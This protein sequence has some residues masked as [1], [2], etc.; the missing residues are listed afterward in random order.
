MFACMTTVLPD[1]MKMDQTFETV[2][3]PKLNVCFYKENK[4]ETNKQKKY[5]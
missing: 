2:S 5:I 3:Q 4:K 1:I